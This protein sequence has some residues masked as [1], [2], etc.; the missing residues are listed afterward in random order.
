MT[1]APH[2]S[3]NRFIC[4][5]Y[6]ASTIPVQITDSRFNIFIQKANITRTPAETECLGLNGIRW[7][8]EPSANRI[9]FKIYTKRMMRVPRGDLPQTRT[10]KRCASL[11]YAYRHKCWQCTAGKCVCS[12]SLPAYG[13]AE[14]VYKL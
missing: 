3:H 4:T 5:K 1:S 2:Q 13:W 8:R 10:P 9:Y 14:K 6:N 7:R 12:L 11:L